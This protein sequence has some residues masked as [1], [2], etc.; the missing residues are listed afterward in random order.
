VREDYSAHAGDCTL[1]GRCE[2]VCPADAVSYG[3]RPREGASDAGLRLTRRDFVGSAT[4][5]AAGLGTGWLLRGGGA[6]GDAPIRPPGS[7]PEAEFLARCVRCG[8]CMKVCPTGVLEPAGARWGWQALWTPAANMDRSFCEL[9]CVNCTRVCPTGAIAPLAPRDK[10]RARMGLAVVNE[11][12]CV[13]CGDCVKVCR[14]EAM[15]WMP[16]ELPVVVA[17]RCTGCGECQAECVRT[18]VRETKQLDRTAIEV[19]RLDARIPGAGRTKSGITPS[20]PPGSPR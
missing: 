7:L 14:Y 15:E 20:P 9:A 19:R 13:T 12:T 5:G 18:R 3:V 11:E 4:A 1:C 17:D 16:G 6:A 8:A 10:P 2:A